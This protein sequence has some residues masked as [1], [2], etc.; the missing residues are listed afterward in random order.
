M[1]RNERVEARLWEWGEWVRSAGE[2]D[3]GAGYPSRNCLDPDW[4]RPGQGMRPDFKVEL[5][6]RG[7]MTHFH[8]SALSRTLQETL[9]RHYCANES[10]AS[11][12]AAMVSSP[13]TVDQRIWRAHAAL[14]HLL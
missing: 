11:I 10:V 4:G 9:V 8:I 2:C 6:G 3:K 13:A 14:A 1:A 5:P 12:A 7:A